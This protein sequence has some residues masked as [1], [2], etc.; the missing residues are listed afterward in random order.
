MASRRTG[1]ASS[2]EA[3]FEPRRARV[4]RSTPLTKLRAA[5]MGE[6]VRLLDRLV[7]RGVGG[8]AFEEEK[9]IESR[10]ARARAGRP[11]SDRTA[12]CSPPR[13]RGRAGAAGAG[14][15][16]TSSCRS[17]WSRSSNRASALSRKISVGESDCSV[18]SSTQPAAARTLSCGERRG[19]DPA[20]PAGAGLRDGG[21]RAAA[22]RH[23]Q[24]APPQA[25]ASPARQPLRS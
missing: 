4:L 25:K 6:Q 5:M 3:V 19:G 11:R 16:P 14:S 15:H 8:H 24:V 9:L 22:A 10:P 7:H 1:S 18:R 2:T 21:W 12:G 20:V 23:G 13:S 17:R